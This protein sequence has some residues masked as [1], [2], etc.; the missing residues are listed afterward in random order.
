MRMR[1]NWWSNRRISLT[2]YIKAV[3]NGWILDLRW[4]IKKWVKIAERKNLEVLLEAQILR[5]IKLF[6]FFM[7]SVPSNTSN[8]KFQYSISMPAPYFTLFFFNRIQLD[9]P[10]NPRTLTLAQL[11]LLD[12]TLGW[13]SLHHIIS[14]SH[15]TCPC[16]IT[17][18]SLMK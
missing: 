15:P 5:F 7:N 16:E 18:I 9:G 11:G 1:C 17:I 10:T 6:L 14:D 8:S 4:I 3:K 2:E 12:F 13:F